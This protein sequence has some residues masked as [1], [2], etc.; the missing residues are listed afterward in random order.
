ML[1][2]ADF[3]RRFAPWILIATFALLIALVGPAACRKL[4]QE[5]A[6]ARLGEQSAS[7][8]SRNGEDAVAT[9]GAAARREQQSDALT[10]ANE[11]EIRDAQGA[12][13]RLDPA[14]RDAGLGGLCRRPAYRDHERCRLRRAAAE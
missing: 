11:K 5:S 6:R 14:V 4:N 8:A 9:V 12:D 13:V 2:L 3:A 10:R 7:S 1:I